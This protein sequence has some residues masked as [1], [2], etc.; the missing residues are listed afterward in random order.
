MVKCPNCDN[1]IG[2]AKFC[3][4]CGTEIK[5]EMLCPHCNTE[6]TEESIFCPECGKK[7]KDDD[8]SEEETKSEENESD[9]KESEEADSKE[10]TKSEE[11]TNETRYCPYCNTKIYDDDAE[12]CPECGKKLEIDPQSF[13]GIKNIINWKR[14]IILSII[15]IIFAAALS[16]LFSFIFGMT[17]DASKILYPIGFIISLIIVIGIFGSFEDLINGGLLGIITGLIIGLSCNSIIELSSGFA[18]SYEMLSGYAPIIFTILGAIIGIASTKYL[19]K[20]VTKYI[21]VEK[22]F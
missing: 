19:R 16:L 9:K 3:N 7:I 12:H 8:V 6:I 15:S 11:D 14:L 21:D 20:S 4:K 5:K 1:E 10:E 17:G 22:M 18:F 2:E 13:E